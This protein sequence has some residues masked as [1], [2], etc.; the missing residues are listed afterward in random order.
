MMIKALTYDYMNFHNHAV[1]QA[2]DLYTI[3]DEKMEL[4]RE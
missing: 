4:Q 3:K 1:Q 2:K